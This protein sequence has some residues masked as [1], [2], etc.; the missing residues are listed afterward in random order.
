MRVMIVVTHLLGTGHLSRALALG[1]AFRAA[2]HSVVLVSGGMAAPHLAGA[3][4]PDMVQLPA[5]RSD[6]TRF[7]TLLDATGSP[8][9]PDL[10]AR[11]TAV[12]CETVQDFHPDVLLTELF[13]FGRRVLR[14]EFLA[15]LDSAQALTPRPVILTSIRDIL[16]PPSK[17]ARAEWVGQII[18]RYYDGILVHSDPRATRLEQSWPLTKALRARLLYTG[19]V[20]ALAAPMPDAP[21][22]DGEIVVS[23]GGGAVGGLVYDA[24]IEAARLMPDFPW[25]FLVG[26]ADAAAH[27]AAL[28]QKAQTLPI[29]IEPVRPDFRQILHRAAASVSMCGYNTALDLLQTGVPAVLI[30]FDAGGETEQT[31]RATSLS[32]LPGIAVL[33]AATANGETL[34]RSLGKVISDG[35]RDGP[36]VKIDGALQTVAIACQLA[37]ARV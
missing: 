7:T 37:E 29:T 6:G 28:K 34:A 33:G 14:E 3:N 24:A 19:Y 27:I 36:T 13:P 22:G 9:T 10:L 21:V 4:G 30:P 18:N 16:A 11:R 15:L 31:L 20:S 17:P 1:H 32:D 5:I 2:G 25:R 26:G 12:L 35:R 23:T 8:V